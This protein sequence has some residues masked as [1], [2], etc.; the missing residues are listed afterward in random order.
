MNKFLTILFLITSAISV[1]AQEKALIADG[2][3]SPFGTKFL[4]EAE[5]KELTGAFQLS[6]TIPPSS[7]SNSYP[8][9]AGEEF[10]VKH[11]T[12]GFFMTNKVKS[13]AYLYWACD[14]KNNHIYS[15][16]IVKNKRKILAH[17]VFENRLDERIDNIGDLNG[18]S[19]DELAIYN[20]STLNEISYSVNVRFVEFLPNEIKKFGE[21]EIFNPASV[22]DSK[23]NFNFI[24]AKIYAEKRP[25]NTPIFWQEKLELKNAKLENLYDKTDKNWQIIQPSQQIKL[26]DDRGNYEKNTWKFG[27]ADITS[28][29]LVIETVLFILLMPVTF[30]GWYYAKWGFQSA[31]NETTKLQK[32]P[33]SAPLE[34]KTDLPA[35]DPLNCPSCGAGVP[36]Q[37]D[38]MICPSCN[39]EFPVPKEYRELNIFRN[40]AVISLKNAEKY[41]SWVHFL[42]SNWVTYTL[43]I[44]AI[45]TI[46]SVIVTFFFTQNSIVYY[47]AF[48][49]PHSFGLGAMAALFW[50][51]V[52]AMLGLG[53]RKAKSGVLPTLENVE[54]IG[55]AENSRCSQCGGGIEFGKSDFA[56]ICGYCGVETYRAKMAWKARNLTNDVRQ[57][58]NF[59]LTRAMKEYQKSVQEFVNLP[60]ALMCV[61]LIPASLCVLFSILGNLRSI[62]FDN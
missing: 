22:N 4:L 45:L 33:E 27:I 41:W 58:A 21:T 30:Y 52:F 37:T 62:F 29:F 32:S 7:N 40:Q 56:T 54:K 42:T 28:G 61:L 44:L 47:R 31:K 20:F 5:L 6:R 19:L 59:S 12:E 43:L 51:S 16:I 3:K 55:I 35:L 18:D 57:K 38:K 50:M 49:V 34:T 26:N 9:K 25:D 10:T 23:T 13:L 2:T 15:G 36:L 53:I 24:A 17:Y 46:A 48:F 8:C 39:T 60:L 11:S 1:T 14:K